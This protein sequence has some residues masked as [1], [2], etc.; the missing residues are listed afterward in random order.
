M[1]SAPDKRR[2]IVTG[3]ARG[4]GLA[5]AQ[6]FVADG[7]RV[8]LVDRDQ[9]AG[10]AAATDL[11]AEFHL[12]DVAL[13]NQLPPIVEHAVK[14][15]GGVDV[16]INNAGIAPQADFFDL[17]EEEFDR[18][19]A[20]NLKAVFLLSQ[21]A[22]RRMR[23]QATGGA[24]VNLSSINAVLN[25]PDR[26]AYCVSKGGVAQLTRNCAIALA[27]LGIRVNA[28][29]PGTIATEMAVGASLDGAMLRAVQARTPLGRL[30]QA[31]EIAAIAA[32]LASDEASYI[33]GQTIYADGGR[34][35]LNYTMPIASG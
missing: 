8:L 32:F 4:I 10:E 30:G 29:G 1:A 7:A 15:F 6:R 28:I 17:T 13:S 24:I 31:S 23:D 11:A 34:L 16:L 21:A 35:G 3:A 19:M 14:A 18:V 27:P 33:T 12:A 26:L 22:A 5:C 20:V 2:V 25:I 9:A